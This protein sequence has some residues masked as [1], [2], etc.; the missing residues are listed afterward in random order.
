MTDDSPESF[1]IEQDRVWRGIEVLSRIGSYFLLFGAGFI[2]GYV[3]YWL[4][5]GAHV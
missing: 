4:A 5:K 2:L 3:I 1:F